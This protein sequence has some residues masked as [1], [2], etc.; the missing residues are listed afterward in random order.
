MVKHLI[1]SSL[2]EALEAIDHEPYKMMAGG[3]DL[4]VQ[5]RSWAETAPH[6]TQ[7]VMYIFNL[8]ELNYIRVNQGVMYIGAMVPVARLLDHDVTPP[9]L[10]EALK[11]MASPALRNLATLAGNVGNASPA[12]DTLPILYVLNAKVVVASVDKERVI[13]IEEV[14]VAPRK[15]SL[16]SNEIIKEIQIPLDTFSHILFEKVGGRKADAI[17]KISFTGAVLIEQGIIKDFR[18]AFG[19]VSATILRKKDIEQKYIGLTISELKQQK[20][21]IVESYVSMIQP[22][23]DQRSNKEYRKTVAINLFNHYID[24]L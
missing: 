22:I 7:N 17:S 24:S 19:A 6:F 21:T 5:N 4:M 3:T 23:D 12:G 8:E 14:I 16:Q 15:L 1:P 11:V 2:Q 18:I 10:K 9:L 20:D 13:P